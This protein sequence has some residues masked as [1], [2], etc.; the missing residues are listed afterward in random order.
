MQAQGRI[1]SCNWD[2]YDTRHVVFQ[3]RA[4]DARGAGGRLLAGVPRLLSLVGD[5]S[6]RLRRKPDLPGRL[7]HL[8]YAG[9]WKKF[10]PLWDL[11]IRLKRVSNF[12]P[13]LERL[14]EGRQSLALEEV[15]NSPLSGVTEQAVE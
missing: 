9:G 5:I 7:R 1:T 13:L 2:L 6:R 14:L 4:D 10:E 12:L 3:P 11:V 15:F 8:A